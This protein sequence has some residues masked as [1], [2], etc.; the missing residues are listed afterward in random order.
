MG[1]QAGI[2]CLNKE[3]YNFLREFLLLLLLELGVFGLVGIER[4]CLGKLWVL[5]GELGERGG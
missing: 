1:I 4:D 5:G 3:F 2:H